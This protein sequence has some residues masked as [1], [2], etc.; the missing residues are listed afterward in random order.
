MR[1]YVQ[2]TSPLWGETQWVKVPTQKEPE[3]VKLR[4]RFAGESRG[5]CLLTNQ[6]SGRG[7][8]LRAAGIERCAG[9]VK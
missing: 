7:A 8:T 1:L 3:A 2:R 4:R 9:L 6:A 5:R